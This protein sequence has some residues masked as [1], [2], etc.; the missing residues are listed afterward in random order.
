VHDTVDD[1]L[2]AADAARLSGHAAE[3]LSFFERI[4]AHHADDGRAP[5]AAFSSGRVLLTLARIPEAAKAFEKAIDLG[6]EE[7]L[8]ENAVARAVEAHAQAGEASRA[9]A[10]ARTYL[11]RYPAGRWVSVMQVYAAQD[12]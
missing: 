3:A 7:P 4:T 8:R 6:A 9:T 1:L 10:L 11:E 12:Q 5:M 2:L